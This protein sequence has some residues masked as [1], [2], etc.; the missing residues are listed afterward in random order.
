MI[1]SLQG[2]R[3]KHTI[4]QNTLSSEGAE[5][6]E[7]ERWNSENAENL[8]DLLRSLR[9]KKGFGL[10][11]VQCSPAQ[12]T[13]IIRKIQ[14]T[15][16]NKRL[17]Q[18]ELDRQS[19]TLYDKLLES[20][21]EDAYAIACVTGVEQALYSYEDTKRLAGWTSE[22][23]YN[24]SWKG[25]PR[26]LNHLNKFR[27]TFNKNLPIVLIFFVPRFVIDYFVQ[28]A[29]D[30][31]DWRSGLFKFNECL[32]NWNIK[33][34]ELVGKEYD[35]YLRLTSK[36]RLEKIFSIKEIISQ[37]N[38]LDLDQKSDLFREQGHLFESDGDFK[39]ALDC[40]ERASTIQPDKASI[41]LSRGHLLLGLQRYKDAIENFDHVLEIQPD[42]YRALD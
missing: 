18:F 22:E 9:R 30:F 29:P 27:E 23:I 17:E 8:N 2:G 31:F 19:E 16:P 33:T 6:W 21:Q 41:W 5:Y 28:R 10:F 40:Y 7:E 11:F 15:L 35:V 42:E 25:T 12:A 34:Q 38:N 20:Y 37:V 32:E 3:N 4:H 14:E 36:Q 13:K 39:Q 26:I 24:Y 1:D